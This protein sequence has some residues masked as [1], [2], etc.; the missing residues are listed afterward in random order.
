MNEYSAF[1]LLW[2]SMSLS[3]IW[4]LEFQV[5]LADTKES[6]DI[7]LWGTGVSIRIVHV[8]RLWKK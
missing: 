1:F 3:L 6:K 8:Q 7:P 2:T 5:D 4:H